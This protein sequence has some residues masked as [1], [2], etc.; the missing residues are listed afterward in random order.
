MMQRAY[1]KRNRIGRFAT[2]KRRLSLLVLSEFSI[3]LQ[4]NYI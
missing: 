2:I 3:N 4:M 1:G